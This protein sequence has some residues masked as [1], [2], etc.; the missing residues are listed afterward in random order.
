ME[1][2]HFCKLKELFEETGHGSVTK[3]QPKIHGLKNKFVNLA[4]NFAGNELFEAFPDIGISCNFSWNFSR[5]Q[6]QV[7][8]LT[9]QLSIHPGLSS[10]RRSSKERPRVTHF[11][12]D[13]KEIW[14][15]TGPLESPIQVS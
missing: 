3:L 9:F 12:L 7:L 4:R 5:I 14:S 11:W 1:I 13:F 15:S 8:W 6:G 10:F 2:K